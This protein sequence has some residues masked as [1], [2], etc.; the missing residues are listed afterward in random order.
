M[1]LYG[2]SGFDTCGVKVWKYRIS[3]ASNYFQSHVVETG[4]QKWTPFSSRL[5]EQY[6]RQFY[7]DQ[8]D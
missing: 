3:Y 4:I 6:I 1:G 7:V 5:V 8:G 2:P